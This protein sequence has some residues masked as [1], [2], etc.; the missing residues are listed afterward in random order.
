[1]Q[2]KL[3]VLCA[4]R[5]GEA[6]RRLARRLVNAQP[7][8]MRMA[9]NGT[10]ALLMAGEFAPD[11]LVV[12][13]V[14]PGLDGA[15]LIDRMQARLGVRMPLVIAGA[16]LPFSVEGFRRRGVRRIVRVPWEDEELAQAVLSAAM[17]VHHAVD[18]P[19][20]E[21]LA[22]DAARLLEEMGMR[23]TLHGCLYLSLA[24]ALAAMDEARLC[25]IGESIY[26]PVA[27]RQKTTPQNVERLIRHA[28]ES[29]V[30]SERD[31]VYAFFGNTIDP[32]R[33]KPTNAQMIG[34]LS[35]RLRIAAK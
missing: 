24:A 13:A 6:A 18:W 1:M 2:P 20:A 10:D 23:R 16:V 8:T 9:A 30:D 35:Q 27:A 3:S 33:G 22:E 19:R 5:D 26:A 31:G 29:T 32:T 4:M 25:A 21:V 28:V 7:C 15:A 11:I 14:L 34:L 17:T 12:E